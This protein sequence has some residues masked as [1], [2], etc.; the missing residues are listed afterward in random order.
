MLG[1]DALLA[2]LPGGTPKRADYGSLVPTLSRDE[3]VAHYGRLVKYVVGRL[4]VSVPGLFDHDD[5]MQAGTLGLLRA[6][7]AYK[8]EAAASMLKLMQTVDQARMSS[9]RSGGTP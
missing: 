2:I 3:L 6:I 7:D 1:N 8:P 9:G 4:G 5:A